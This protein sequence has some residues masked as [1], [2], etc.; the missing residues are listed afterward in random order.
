[1]KFANLAI[2]IDD[3]GKGGKNWYADVSIVIEE[4]KKEVEYTE[5]VLSTEDEVM[6]LPQFYFDFIRQYQK[7][8]LEYV[9]EKYP[10]HIIGNDYARIVEFLNKTNDTF[11]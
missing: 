6:I 9:S 1:M 10:E 4:N 3:D 8:F 11:K 2:N 5:Q 7:D